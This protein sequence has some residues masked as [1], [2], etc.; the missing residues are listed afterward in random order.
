M[1]THN[2]YI[3]LDK[4]GYTGNIFVLFLQWVLIGSQLKKAP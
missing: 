2:T 4:S 3:G 1:S